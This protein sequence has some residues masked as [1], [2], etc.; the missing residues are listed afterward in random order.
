MLN[1]QQKV[2]IHAVAKQSG[3]A[4]V[5]TFNN[6]YFIINFHGRIILCEIAVHGGLQDTSWP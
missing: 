4:S 3:K 1:T 2:R 6:L 5:L